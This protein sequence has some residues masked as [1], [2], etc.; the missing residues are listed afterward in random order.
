MSHSHTNDV[1][2][3]GATIPRPSPLHGRRVLVIAAHPDDEILFAGA[4]L[5]HCRMLTI[6]HL[7]DGATSRAIAKSQG[8]RTRRQYAEARKQELTAALE[9]GNIE[10]QCRCLGYR[11]T[12]SCLSMS[13]AT[14]TLS[15]LIS[16]ERPDVVLT[17][18]YE[19]GHID[20]DTAAFVAHSAVQFCNIRPELWEMACY[21]KRNGRRFTHLFPDAENDH[22]WTITLTPDE[23]EAKRRML[24]CFRTQQFIINTFPKDIETLR[25]AP[26]H[27]FTT[28]PFT[29]PLAYETNDTGCEGALWRLLTLSRRQQLS[30]GT[31]RTHLSANAVRL[32]MW[33]TLKSAAFRRDHPSIGTPYERMLLRLSGFFV[34]Q[35][36]GSGSTAHTDV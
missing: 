3:P 23:R 11:D 30:S 21:H 8:F 4:Q 32:L 13:A 35:H 26:A 2:T 36:P 18:A 15:E 24:E 28:A 22:S 17:H 34:K 5:S 31:G 6:V 33:L 1:A 12:Y 27:D 16:T 9:A 20:H 10:A 25:P 14:R 7:T 19:G 29:G